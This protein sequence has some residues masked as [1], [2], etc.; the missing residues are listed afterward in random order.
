V[1]TEY[2]T[3]AQLEEIER[4]GPPKDGE[5]ILEDGRRVPDPAFTDE[6]RESFRNREK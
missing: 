5:M 3:P 1:P 2:P 6:E 4:N